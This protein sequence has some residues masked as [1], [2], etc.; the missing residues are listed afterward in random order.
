VDVLR[1][2]GEPIPWRDLELA[3]WK[4]SAIWF[5]R[6]AMEGV[7]DEILSSEAPTWTIDMY[8]LLD[9]AENWAL[10][11]AGL[12]VLGAHLADTAP[13]FATRLKVPSRYEGKILLQLQ[14]ALPAIGIAELRP[15]LEFVMEAYV[16]ELVGV[17]AELWIAAEPADAIDESP[18]A[19]GTDE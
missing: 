16:R 5:V 12:D 6:L 17:G 14:V 8:A 18:E 1:A 11:Q 3:G 15:R 19:V 4:A 13:F 10:V 9:P 7:A 2:E